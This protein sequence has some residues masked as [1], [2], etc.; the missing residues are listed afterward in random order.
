MLLA[1]LIKDCVHVIQHGHDF[2]GAYQR[3]NVCESHHITEQNRHI[4]E[5]LKQQPQVHFSFKTNRF[6]LYLW[7]TLNPPPPFPR[8][9][10]IYLEPRGQGG[11]AL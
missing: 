8:L 10:Y 6:N 4:M 11:A 2:H 5:H 3:T 7:V 1:D 9:I